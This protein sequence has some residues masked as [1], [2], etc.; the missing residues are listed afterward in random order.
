VQPELLLPEA[1]A[2]GEVVAVRVAAVR[3]AAVRLA[4]GIV[5]IP[6]LEAAA[7]GVVSSVS[8]TVASGARCSVFADDGAEASTGWLVTSVC[9]SVTEASGPE[10]LVVSEPE[11][12]CGLPTAAA[13]FES[14]DISMRRSGSAHPRLYTTI[15]RAR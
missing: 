10:E 14:V 2:V 5:L 13:S 9:P 3:V 11:S 4:T 8:S 7:S 6:P 12:A 1:G 15:E